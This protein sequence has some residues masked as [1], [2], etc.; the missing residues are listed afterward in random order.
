VWKSS[1]TAQF[2]R[3]ERRESFSTIIVD[4]LCRRRT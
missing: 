4:N 1:S 2:W 3:E